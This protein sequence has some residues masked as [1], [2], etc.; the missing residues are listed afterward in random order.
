M[1][2]KENISEKDRG[3]RVMLFKV[4]DANG[5]EVVPWPPTR[6]F[7]ANATLCIG[8]APKK[9][10]RVAFCTS[11]GQTTHA[12]LEPTAA[13]ANTEYKIVK[14]YSYRRTLQI[15]TLPPE[16]IGEMTEA[17]L[18]YDD[19]YTLLDEQTL[20]RLCGAIGADKYEFAVDTRESSA[21]KAILARKGLKQP[22][23]KTG[24]KHIQWQAEQ[25]EGD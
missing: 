13:P 7:P 25:R 17:G 3:Q 16:N 6:K 18:A 12:S 23:T 1:E 24:L 15:L 11:G 9:A 14:A 20:Q 8:V 19:P 21:A 10:I 2:E 5:E 4:K 22:P